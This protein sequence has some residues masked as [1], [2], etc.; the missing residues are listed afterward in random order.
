MKRNLS[1]VLAL[2]ML[3][4]TVACGNETV[5]EETAA[6][7]TTAVTETET[8]EEKKPPF[9]ACDYKGE[10]FHILANTGNTIYDFY[11]F[12]DEQT[13][14]AMNDAIYN[15]EALTEE[16]LGVDITHLLEGDHWTQAGTIEKVVMAGDDAY[17]LVLTHC[18]R[19]VP[20][21]AAAGH[22]Y[23]WYNLTYA[24]L[25]GP[26]WNQSCNENL[27]MDG[28][29]YVA[30]SDYMLADPYA[31]LFNKD[32]VNDFSLE[33]PYELVKSGE[34][35]MDKLVELSDVVGSDLDGNGEMDINDRYGLSSNDDSLWNAFIYAAGLR[36][37]TKS[38]DGKN[39]TLAINTPEMV[40]LVEKIHHI[41][42][43]SGDTFVWKFGAAD[44]DMLTIDSGRVLFQLASLRGMADFRDSDVDFGVIPYPKMEAHQKTYETNDWS[45]FMCVP[46][47][48][49]NP[50]MVG[51]VCEML[52]YYSG[53]TTVP[54]YYDILLGQ[55]LARDEDSREM[56]ELIFDNIV[57]DAGMTYFGLGASMQ[58][59][60][61]TLSYAVVREDNNNFASWYAK[62]SPPSEKQ[63]ADFVA[64]ILSHE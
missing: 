9:E 30:I 18:M 39:M 24:D 27:S 28:K 52:A 48:V 49:G 33:S 43:V 32:M 13:G 29:L 42:N 7:D 6:A 41:A 44:E 5:N 54:A 55:K 20:D 60:V 8:V 61:Y 1:L 26:Y 34:W 45:G 58:Q 21:M 37:V 23:N 10:T 47:T 64:D 63:I 50:D 12:A 57:Y 3:L 25:D 16:Y 38:D 56:L 11:F 22:L 40:T 14:E 46:K 15:R 53:E 59:L 35:T 2:L 31:V 4:S 62:H 51:K 19:S 17:Q 36:M